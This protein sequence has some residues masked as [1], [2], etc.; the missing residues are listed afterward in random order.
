MSAI[1]FEGQRGTPVAFAPV[2]MKSPEAGPTYELVPLGEADDAFVDTG[3]IELAFDRCKP[4]TKAA[5]PRPL[6][7]APPVVAAEPPCIRTRAAFAMTPRRVSIAFWLSVVLTL[8]SWW[9]RDEL[10]AP[11]ALLPATHI[12]PLQTEAARTPFTTKVGETTY[13]IR[14]VYRYELT[15]LVVSAHDT[16]VF[17]DSMHLDA[18]DDLNVV[19][20]C[21]IWGMNATSGAYQHASFSSGQ[22][23]CW[24]TWSG[25]PREVPFAT[26]AVSNNHLLTDRT[27]LASVMLSARVGDQVHF[28][29][30]LSEY[31]HDNGFHFVRGTS[32]VRTDT[33]N[34]ACE[35]VFVDQFE[36]LAR[37]GGGFRVL[38]WVGI[39][40]TLASVGAWFSAPRQCR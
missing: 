32:T 1:R 7:V 30:W 40:A 10:P 9:R 38:F 17:W 5:Y 28:R 18:H 39:V 22:Y 21:V 16:H 31:E 20:L 14:P 23:T 25:R 12:E 26:S 24:A 36:I 3:F 15:G 11:D 37:G 34:G 35:T 2:A 6:P 13:H 8:V 27:E 19:D 29:G 33:G 4:A